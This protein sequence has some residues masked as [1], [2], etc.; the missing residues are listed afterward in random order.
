MFF[1]R[2]LRVFFLSLHQGRQNSRPCIKSL[3]GA[4]FIY[5]FSRKGIIWYDID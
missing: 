5:F 3:A 1:I 2:P 4:F